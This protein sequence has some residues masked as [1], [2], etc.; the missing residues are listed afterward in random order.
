MSVRRLEGTKRGDGVA[1]L[2]GPAANVNSTN[3]RIVKAVLT[4]ALYPNVAKI[5]FP[6]LQF[7]QMLA[8]SIPVTVQ[9]HEL[10]FVLKSGGACSR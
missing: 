8:G 2:S 9:P 1:E 4:A 3:T 5:I 10:R 7:K 6:E